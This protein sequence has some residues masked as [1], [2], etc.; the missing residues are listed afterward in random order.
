MDI[1]KGIHRN[2]P[3]SVARGSTRSSESLSFTFKSNAGSSLTSGI[4]Y[5]TSAW[6]ESEVSTFY[7]KPK[8]NLA[9]IVVFC[10]LFCGTRYLLRSKFNRCI[11]QSLVNSRKK[12]VPS[13][14]YHVTSTEWSRSHI[15]NGCKTGQNTSANLTITFQ[16][17]SRGFYLQSTTSSEKRKK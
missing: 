16:A 12:M 17:I 11:K 7:F 13:I 3:V 5:D 10:L 14:T 6:T 8:N 4:L 2:S 9:N 15:K 1:S